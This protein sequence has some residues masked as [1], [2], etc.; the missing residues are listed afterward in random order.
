ML[1]VFGMLFGLSR[2]GVRSYGDHFDSS[3]W[4]ALAVSLGSGFVRDKRSGIKQKAQVGREGIASS[5]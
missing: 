5:A 2:A 3:T 4:A 1:A